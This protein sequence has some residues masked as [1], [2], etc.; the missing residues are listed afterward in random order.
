MS[1][2]K[3]IWPLPAF[4]FSVVFGKD[5]EAAGFQEVSGISTRIETETLYEGGNNNSVFHLP[6]AVK[7]DNLILK[8][9]VLPLESSLTDWCKSTFENGFSEELE[10]RN[11][12]VNLLDEKKEPARSWVFRNAY[13][14]SWKLDTLNSTKNELAI[15][16]I[17]LCYS[18][19]KRTK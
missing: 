9:A 10:T 14:V 19:Q 5:E 2:K 17:E 18:E 6:K 16:E 13:P 8:R 1:E 15:E 3:E 7:H 12:T 4:H 11:I